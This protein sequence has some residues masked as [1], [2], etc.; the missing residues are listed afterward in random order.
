MKILVCTDGSQESVKAVEEASKIAD[1][2]QV[3]E[4]SIIHVYDKNFAGPYW[5]EFQN[6]T[7]EDLDRFNKEVEQSKE[8]AKN[9][10]LEAEKIF[11]A[12]NIKVNTILKKGNPAETIVEVATEEGFDMVVLGRR[13]LSGLKKVFLGSVSNAVLQEIDTTVLIVK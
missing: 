8:K 5:S 10:L 7:Q 9:T 11:Q 3:D 6:V 2:C 4:V 13:G 1:G 12:K